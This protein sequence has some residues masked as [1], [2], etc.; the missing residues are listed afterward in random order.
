MNA[1]VEILDE[2][3]DAR[4][5]V[6][7]IRNKLR[8][9][10]YG[11]RDG[12]IPV[13]Y[14]I[15]LKILESEIAVYEDG[16]FKPVLDENLMM[17]LAKQ[18]QTFEFQ[19][20]RLNGIRT[21]LLQ[22]F[23]SI[24]ESHKAAPSTLLSIVRPLCLFI[25]ELPEYSRNTETLPEQTLALRKAILAAKE[26]ADLVFTAIPQALGV[27]LKD[28]DKDETAALSKHL[29]ASLREL[30]L[31]YADLQQ[32]TLPQGQPTRDPARQLPPRPPHDVGCE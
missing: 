6:D 9:R 14:V 11:I 7:R 21:E 31:A 28:A 19:V 17:R 26:P 22:K 4:V 30:R 13:L 32:P 15:A 5:S 18:P 1:I 2:T 16:E 20:C 25:D 10:P 12:L 23:A 24:L 8:A 3:P 29:S 27:D